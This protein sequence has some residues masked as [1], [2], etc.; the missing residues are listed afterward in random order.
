MALVGIELETKYCLFVTFKSTVVTISVTENTNAELVT[1]R[2][3]YR[4]IFYL[5]CVSA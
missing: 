3:R 4:K 2:A 1:I 5:V